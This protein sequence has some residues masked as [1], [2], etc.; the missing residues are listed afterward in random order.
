MASG[1]IG[2]RQAMVQQQGPVAKLGAMQTAVAAP[3]PALADR[4]C[5]KK[6]LYPVFDV[7]AWSL[8]QN[9]E[10]SAPGHKA[11]SEQNEKKGTECSRHSE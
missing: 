3:D 8:L 5:G 11:E 4:S 6:E 2:D 10:Q 7:D 9:K 1:S